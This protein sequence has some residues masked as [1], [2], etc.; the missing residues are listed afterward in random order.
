MQPVLDR[1]CVACHKAGKADGAVPRIAS[2]RKKTHARDDKPPGVQEHGIGPSN[3]VAPALVLKSGEWPCKS[4][5]R[6]RSDADDHPIADCGSTL[7]PQGPP[8]IAYQRRYPRFHIESLVAALILALLLFTA[9]ILPSRTYNRH[10]WPFI[11]MAREDRMNTVCT[12]Y[13]GPWPFDD[14]PIRHF[15]LCYLVVN[16]L[17]CLVLHASATLAVEH[18]VRT[19]GRIRFGMR[20]LFV[21]LTVTAATFAFIQTSLVLDFLLFVF[22]HC[23]AYFL[24]CLCIFTF[25]HWLVVRRRRNAA[26]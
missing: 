3:S 2:G 23:F 25:G 10:G 20:S 19:Y 22:P 18:L 16:T 6:T 14:P 13:Y 26:E 1:K 24:V 12:I 17:I 9:N 15:R 21:V 7:W 8:V 5:R 4:D 11:Y